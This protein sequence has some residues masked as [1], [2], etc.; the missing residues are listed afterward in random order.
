MEDGGWEGG[1]RVCIS[2]PATTE[3][4]VFEERSEGGEEMSHVDDTGYSKESTADRDNGERKVLGVWLG[5]WDSSR[6]N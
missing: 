6:A 5:Q 2:D 4:V 1:G 3:K